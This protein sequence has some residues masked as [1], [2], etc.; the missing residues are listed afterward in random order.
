MLPYPKTQPKT[1]NPH[2]TLPKNSTKNSQPTRYPSP[3]NTCEMML[4]PSK[5]V[6][7]ECGACAYTNKDATRRDCL[8]CQIRCPV[9][10]AIVAGATAAATARTTRVD[11][12]GQACI[13]ALPTAGPIVAGEAATSAN[14]A[15]A[16]EAPT[17]AYGPPAVVGSAAMH[18]RWAPQLGGNRASVV[19]C[20]VNTM[21]DIIGN[22]AKN[23]GCN[24]PFHACCGMQLQVGSKV[25]FCQERLIYQEK[26]VLAMYVVGDSTITCKV[27]FLP[28]HLVVRAN[29][30]DGLY[31]RIL[32]IYSNC[33]TNVLKREKFWRN[34]GCCVA[35]VLGNR[36]LLSI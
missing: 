33:C 16:G 29:A 13:A 10:Y 4:C 17:A 3:K 8:A 15:I 23:R 32:S 22:S 20:L 26:D 28:Q 9:C 7:W 31:A 6:R 35:C 14:G 36:P 2:A 19:A 25:Y 27:G 34:K 24:C 30:H 12:C 1:H 11:C 21:V 5:V 18:H